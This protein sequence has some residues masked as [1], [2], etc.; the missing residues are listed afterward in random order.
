MKYYPTINSGNSM[1][2]SSIHQNLHMIMQTKQNKR[3]KNRNK[4][5]Q[6]LTKVNKSMLKIRVKITII[7]HKLNGVKFVVAL[8]SNHMHH[9]TVTYFTV[10]EQQGKTSFVIFK[11]KDSF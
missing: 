10:L 5:I 1:T 2:A 7:K 6:G 11:I 4:K 9:I 3:N 8:T